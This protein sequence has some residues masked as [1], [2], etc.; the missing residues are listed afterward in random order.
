MAPRDVLFTN[1]T[2][3]KRTRKFN[4]YVWTLTEVLVNQK[5][6]N[7]CGHT[8]QMAP[9]DVLLTNTNNLTEKFSSLQIN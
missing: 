7:V 8:V 2:V 4:R 6:I 9:R 5:I 3:L 1:T